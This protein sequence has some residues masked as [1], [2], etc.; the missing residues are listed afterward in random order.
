MQVLMG[1][2]EQSDRAHR[3]GRRSMPE[4]KGGDGGQVTK[5]DRKWEWHTCEAHQHSYIK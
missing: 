4:D 2:E 3:A 1:A 5:C